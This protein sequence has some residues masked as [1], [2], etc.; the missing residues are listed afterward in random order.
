METK[1][2]EVSSRPSDWK[3]MLLSSQTKRITIQCDIP[4]YSSFLLLSEKEIM[5]LA[6]VT[7]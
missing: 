4:L 3:F 5:D 7:H 1:V 2:A 6:T